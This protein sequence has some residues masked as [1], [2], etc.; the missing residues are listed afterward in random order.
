MS[1]KNYRKYS[2][3]VQTINFAHSKWP[4]RS[5]TETETES[6][7]IS[8]TEKYISKSSS[9][10]VGKNNSGKSTIVKLLNTLQNTKSGSRNVFKYTDF[11]L[12]LNKNQN[13]TNQ[14]FFNHRL[15][16]IGFKIDQSNSRIT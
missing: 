2:E 15:L 4:D 1:I 7:K 9:L 14:V 12:I 6:E 11:N 13:Q 3:D 16:T 10:I 8:I 5:G